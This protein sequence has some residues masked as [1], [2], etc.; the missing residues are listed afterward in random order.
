[1]LRE[2]PTVNPSCWKT[3]MSRACMSPRT[4][5]RRSPGL[6]ALSLAV[7][8]ASH[9]ASAQTSRPVQDTL[10]SIDRIVARERERQGLPGLQVAVGLNGRVVHSRAVGKADIENAVALTP[11][12]LIRT[13]SIAK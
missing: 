3:N 5:F 9:P 8:F 10:N 1:M 11:T 13:G 12:S 6:V 7:A 2:Q 4:R